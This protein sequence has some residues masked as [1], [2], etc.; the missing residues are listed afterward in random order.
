MTRFRVVPEESTID[1]KG[2]TSVHPLH[3]KAHSLSGTIDVEIGPDG[4]PDLSQPY[5]AELS[6]PATAI[7]WG[8]HM[9]DRETQ[10][11][12][13]VRAYPFIKASVEQASLIE[14]NAHLGVRVKLTLRGQTRVIDGQASVHVDS[15]RLVV[16][17][18]RVLD[19]REFGMEPPRLLMLKVDPQVTVRARIVAAPET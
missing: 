13:D 19:I 6:L 3:G 8:G 2:Q 4:L 1:V 9:Y 7:T 17:G 15:G 16:E 5:A 11:R 10:R 12:L 18:E 14:G